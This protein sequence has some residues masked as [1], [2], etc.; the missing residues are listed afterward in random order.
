MFSGGII[1]IDLFDQ[2]GTKK[3]ENSWNMKNNFIF[4]VLKQ[5]YFSHLPYYLIKKKKTYFPRGEAESTLG[6]VVFD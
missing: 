1:F 2:T 6:G 5:I 4:H 3:D